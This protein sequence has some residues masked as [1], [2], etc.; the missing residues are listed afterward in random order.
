MEALSREKTPLSVL[1]HPQAPF[2][3]SPVRPVRRSYYE[4]AGFDTVFVETVGAGQKA[5]RAVHSA[6]GLLSIDPTC[7]YR[8]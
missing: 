8:R 5:R 1:H 3:G 2:R 7:R 4:A 6:G